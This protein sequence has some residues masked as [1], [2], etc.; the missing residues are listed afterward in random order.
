MCRN[1]SDSERNHSR[2]YTQ[3]GSEIHIDMYDDMLEIYSPGGMMDGRLIQQLPP[4]PC[5]P[6]EGIHYWRISSVG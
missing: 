2:D 1:R 5:H 3:M 6:K 4:L